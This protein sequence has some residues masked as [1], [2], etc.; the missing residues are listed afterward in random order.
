NDRLD[1]TKQ[2]VSS[3]FAAADYA[4]PNQ[5]TVTPSHGVLRDA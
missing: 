3:A 2:Q 5:F 1:E 4:E